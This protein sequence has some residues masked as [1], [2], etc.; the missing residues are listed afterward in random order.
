MSSSIHN[1]QEMQGVWV[2]SSSFE[3]KV[4]IANP[5]ENKEVYENP[6]FL[7]PQKI[8]EKNKPTQPKS[9][10]QVF[11]N[12]EPAQPKTPPRVLENTEPSRP[13]TPPQQVLENPE[14]TRPQAPIQAPPRN[15]TVQSVQRRT[16]VTNRFQS[17]R[18]NVTNRT[19][20]NKKPCEYVLNRDA[21]MRAGPGFNTPVVANLPAGATVKADF[22]KY[23]KVVTKMHKGVEKKRVLVKSV[24]ERYGNVTVRM[25]WITVSTDKGPMCRR[26]NC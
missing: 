20:M 18:R 12:P 4:F 8:F 14:P 7:Q 15:S 1:P 25:G 3:Q 26:K 21:V 2:F 6:D 22:S 11:E 5:T 9:P 16:Q 13:K 24:R 10:P 17:R 19:R 23:S